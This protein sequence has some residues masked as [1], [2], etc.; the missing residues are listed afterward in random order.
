VGAAKVAEAAES[1][2]DERSD[3]SRPRPQV[4]A[5]ADG[6]RLEEHPLIRAIEEPADVGLERAEP[7]DGGAAAGV[8]APERIGGGSL[9]KGDLGFGA[10]LSPDDVRR[11]EERREHAGDDPEGAE[12]G[13]TER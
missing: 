9:H 7:A 3:G 13:S 4:E 6:E 11:Q 2:C 10:V 5:T 8:Q 1:S 12:S